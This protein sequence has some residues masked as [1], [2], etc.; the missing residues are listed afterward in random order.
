MITFPQSRV[1]GS[2]TTRATPGFRSVSRR[3]TDALHALPVGTD[4]LRRSRDFRLLWLSAIPAG[5][6]MG[7]RQSR[8]SGWMPM[9]RS[10]FTECCVGLVFISPAVAM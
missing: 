8:I 5:M 2:P 4:P 1:K 9:E 3:A 7:A 10:S 6:G